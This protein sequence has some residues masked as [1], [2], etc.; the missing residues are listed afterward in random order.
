MSGGDGAAPTWEYG[1][2]AR[3]ETGR[4]AERVVVHGYRR[5]RAFLRTL[6]GRPIP[7]GDAHWSAPRPG[8]LAAVDCGQCLRAGRAAARPVSVRPPA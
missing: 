7:S 6:C 1:V 5:R 2:V 3:R 4:G 8:D